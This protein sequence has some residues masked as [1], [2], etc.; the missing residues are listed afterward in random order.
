MASAE[1]ASVKYDERSQP[2]VRER[3]NRRREVSWILKLQTGDL[4]CELAIELAESDWGG[5][6][7]SAVDGP[8]AKCFAREDCI[9]GRGAFPEKTWSQIQ[10]RIVQYSGG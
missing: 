10:R 1:P 6:Y 9:E 8:V 4:H 3:R 5:K 7:R 2:L